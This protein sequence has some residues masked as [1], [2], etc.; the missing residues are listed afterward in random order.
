MRPEVGTQPQFRKK[1]PPKN[2]RYDSSLSPSMDWDGQN[3]A[4]ELGEWLLRMIEE[5]SRLEPPH[6]FPQPQEFNGGQVTVLSLQE[7]VQKLKALGKPF[8]NWSGK[9][10]RLSFDVPTL[11]LFVHERLSTKAI[12]ET[13]KSHRKD[14]G[15]LQSDF[16]DMFGDPQHSITDQVLGAYEHRDK[17]VNRMILGDSLV[18]MNSLLEYEGLGGQVQMIY[19]DPPYG[20]KFGSNFQP[21]VRKRDVKHND[22]EDMTR[23]PEMVQ[24]YRDTWEL[25]LHSY[26]SYLRDRLLLCRELLHPTG[27]IFLQIGDDNLH[28][29]RMIL[30]EVF[31]V[32][33]FIVSLLIK[34]KGAQKGDLIDPVNDYVLWYAKDESKCRLKYKQLYAKADLDEEVVSTFRY[35]MLPDGRE[36]TIADLVKETNIDYFNEPRRILLDYPGAA[37][38][39]SNPLTRSLSRNVSV[40]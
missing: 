27:S 36:L 18:V 24:A 39:A 3:W 29:T 33:N 34:K 16:L 23:E 5:A 19:M 20:V 6:Q 31:G 32:S 26:L 4:R 38:F 22:D 1:K 37:I 17:W 15:P 9:A 35:V 2:Y 25:G 28:V 8:L 14:K 12:I 21:F 11:P 30:D 40:F 7:A 10:E 13:L